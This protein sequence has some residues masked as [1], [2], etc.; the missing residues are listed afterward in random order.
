MH[1]AI[2]C[3]VL[4]LL[5]FVSMFI[6]PGMGLLGTLYDRAQSLTRDKSQIHVSIFCVVNASAALGLYFYLYSPSRVLKKRED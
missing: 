2:S 3:M 4:S 6:K 5:F 1:Y